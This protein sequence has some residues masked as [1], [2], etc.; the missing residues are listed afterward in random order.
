MTLKLLSAPDL[1]IT[2]ATGTGNIA[3]TTVLH[4]AFRLKYVSCKFST[5]T[6]NAVTVTL[7]TLAGAAYD[8]VLR[9][10]ATATTTSLVWIPD[11]PVDCVKGDEIAVAWAN[12]AAYEYG[13][14]IV[15]EDI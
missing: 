4:R 1:T 14:E 15:T 12:D 13:L 7:D 5:G 10:I 11:D 2:S 6:S 3:T 8:V 9:S